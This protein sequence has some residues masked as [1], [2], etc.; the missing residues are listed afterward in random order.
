MLYFS[1]KILNIHMNTFKKT[2]F[3]LLI[4]GFFFAGVAFANNS[5]WEGIQKRNEASLEIAGMLL[6][7]EKVRPVLVGFDALL[8][9]VYWVKLNQY[10]GGNIA[11][12][13]P[14]LA[15]FLDFITD[16]DPRYKKAYST[17]ILMLPDEGEFEATEKMIQK[18]EK[19]I[20]EDWN[21]LYQAGSYYFFY[22]DD[23][24]TAI[25]YLKKCQKKEGCLK[26]VS[27]I[28]ASLE[29]KRGKYE[30]SIFQRLGDLQNSEI[31]NDEATAIK[32]RIV[33]SAD[34]LFLNEIDEKKRVKIES[35]SELEGIGFV[36][37]SQKTLKILLSLEEKGVLSLGYDT[38]TKGGGVALIVNK[39]MLDS[40]IKTNLYEWDNDSKKIKTHLF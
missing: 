1:Q 25:D 21:I 23:Y 8:A 28:I 30:L 15:P 29:A 22:K 14:L 32:N 7:G 39:R 5:L 10:I 9:D 37:Q 16:L 19:N 18:A 31:S 33:Q 36:P 24:D 34:L 40:P 11:N 26:S 38:T 2:S 27:S 17:A 20:P 6:D 12:K 4:A 35:L 13:K 3:L